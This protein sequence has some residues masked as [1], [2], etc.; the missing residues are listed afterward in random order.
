MVNQP[1]FPGNNPANQEQIHEVAHKVG[2]AIHDFVDDMP[3]GTVYSGMLY[4]LAQYV[5]FFILGPG[6]SPERAGKVY[7]KIGQ[8]MAGVLN[9]LGVGTVAIDPPEGGNDDSGRKG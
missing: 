1:Q 2:M 8:A 7:D 4:S 6:Y 3:D 9:E 5:D